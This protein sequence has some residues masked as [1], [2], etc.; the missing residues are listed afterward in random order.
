VKFCYTSEVVSS[1]KYLPSPLD[2]LKFFVTQL[3]IKIGTK[4][5]KI[6]TKNG[7]D[8]VSVRIPPPIAD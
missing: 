7:I 4:I 8:I 1:R 6:D 5:L 2:K 3:R